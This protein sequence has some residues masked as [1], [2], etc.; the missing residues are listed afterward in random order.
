[1]KRFLLLISAMLVM[2]S[3]TAQDVYS[4]G[5]YTNS[6]GQVV[7][8]VYK[9]GTLLHESAFGEGENVSTGV[10]V[11]SDNDVYWVRNSENYGDVFK[12]GS[13]YLNNSSGTH[14][15]S[16]FISPAGT[17]FAPGSKISSGVKNAVLWRGSDN[18]PIYT[19]GDGTYDSEA[20]CGVCIDGMCH[21]GGWQRTATSYYGVIWYSGNPEFVFPDGTSVIDIA[22]YNGDFYSLATNNTGSETQLVV[23]KNSNL[24]YTL[25]DSDADFRGKIFVDCGDVYVVG[26]GGANPDILWLNG[27]E[28]YSSS[29]WFMGLTVT[30]DGVYYAG[31]ES[32][33]GSIWKDDEVL[34]SL[35]S[36]DRLLD[37][38]VPDLCTDNN[39]RSLPYYENFDRGNTDWTCWTITDEGN[40]AAP[41]SIW[42]R[43]DEMYHDGDV[44]AKY[45]YNC[46]DYQEGWL[47]SPQISLTNVTTANLN[48]NTLEEYADDYE[49]EGVWISTTGTDPSDFSEV[50]TQ[51][52]PENSWY[53]T[54]IDLTPF[55]GHNIYVAFKYTGTCAHIW[56]VD[57]ISIDGNLGIDDITSSSFA[58]YPNPANDVIRIDGLNKASEVNIYNATGAL[59]KTVVANGHDEINVSDLA[60]GLYLIRFEGRTMKFTKE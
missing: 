3:M 33:S 17:I 5:Y 34:Y 44:Q 30:T 8:A 59:V 60:S 49:Y 58:V 28:L 22:Y 51:G 50:W 35:S 9:N 38:Y 31:S 15:N 12:N 25:V 19:Y 10:V 42:H 20:T 6:D 43:S 26:Y 16:L 32:G 46:G 1:M 24:I 56:Y 29:G 36:C 45:R 23:Y 41:S 39:V 48:F 53:Y 27:E 54:N 14:I 40:N 4:S 11:D 18:S 13:Y 47:I 37:V 2:S 55:T 52:N 7:A 21:I 57:D